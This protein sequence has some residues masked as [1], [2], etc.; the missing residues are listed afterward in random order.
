MDTLV[1]RDNAAVRTNGLRVNGQVA[2]IAITT[3]GSDWYF[4]VCAVMTVSMLAFLGLAFTKPRT[5]RIFHYITSGVVMVAA[6]AYFTMGSHLGWT[7]ID[8]EFQRSSSIVRGMDREIYY[9]RYI[10]WVIT[11]PLLL[12]DLLLTAGQPLSTILWVLLVDEVMIITGLIGALVASSYK[13]GYFVFGCFALFYV[14]YQLAWEARRN[15]NALGPNIGKTFLYCGTLTVFLWFLYPIAWGV[16]EGGNVIAPDSEAVFYG[17]LDLLAK[18]CFGAL[19]LF[20][21]RNI[22]PSDL[23]LALHDYGATDPTVHEK[24]RNG[25]NGHAA[26]ADNTTATPATTV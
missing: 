16:S 25:T 17:V 3:H 20:G 19:L 15:A 23:G 5:E 18:P 1:Q 13:W 12:L 9:A 6:I 7:A 11:T 22:N 8:V 21:H 24:K 2:E 26:T 14:A 10:D 4:A